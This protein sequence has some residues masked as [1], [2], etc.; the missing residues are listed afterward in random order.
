MACKSA[1]RMD[2]MAFGDSM[3]AAKYRRMAMTIK[4]NHNSHNNFLSQSGYLDKNLKNVTQLKLPKGYNQI[5]V[6]LMTN[7]SSVKRE[8]ALPGGEI[9]TIKQS[10]PLVADKDQNTGLAMSR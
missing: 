5:V 7:K 9:T 2:D 8:Y 6:Y 10:H 3:G 4:R 1:M